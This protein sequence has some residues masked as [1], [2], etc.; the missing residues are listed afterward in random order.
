MCVCACVC[1][2]VYMCM[3][4]NVCSSMCNVLFLEFVDNTS[5]GRYNFHLVQYRRGLACDGFLTIYRFIT[6][7]AINAAPNATQCLIYCMRKAF[8]YC[9]CSII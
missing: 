4:D 1:T 7:T 8:V 3:Y 6:L 5:D 2:C 9:P